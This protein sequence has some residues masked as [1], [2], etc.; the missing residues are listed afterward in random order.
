[1][2]H[3]TLRGRQ[4]RSWLS[5]LCLVAVVSAM[6]L[7]AAHAARPADPAQAEAL[8]RSGQHAEAAQLYEQAA[9]RGFMSWDARLALLAARE[10]AAAGQYGPAERMLA[11][12]E[13]R[14]R[15]D[16][17]VL[18]ARIEAEIA[19]ARNDP[20]RALAALQT[21]PTPLPA[22]VAVD[23]LA[24]RAR[25]EF[26]AGLT[27][28]GVRSLEERGRIVGTAD[29]RAANDRLLAD[30]LAQHPAPVAVPPS[31][32]ESERA[33]L[34]LGQLMAAADGADSAAIARRSADWQA[35]HPGHPGAAFLPRASGESPSTTPPAGPTEGSAVIALLLPLS[36]RQQAAGMAV[37]DGVMA[38]WFAAPAAGRPAIRVYDTA[39]GG[40]VAAY[41]RAVS[42]GGS[43]VIGP[44]TREDIAAV[45]AAQP[46]PV[47]T[48]ALNAYPTDAPPPFLF[49]FSLDPE[50][51]AREVARRIAADG[52]VRGVALFPRS[53]WG[54]RL[55]AAFAAE[56][57]ATGTTLLMSSQYY[58]PGARDFSDALRAALGRFGG[59]GDRSDDRSRPAPHRDPVAEAQAGPQ[60]AFV[61]ATP[62]AARALRP[63]L[64]FQ[65]TY[66]LP[67][68]TTSDAWDPS[69]KSAADMDGLVYPE[70]PW[71]LF[72]G[73]GAPELWETVNSTWSRAS[74]GRLRL[75]AFGFDAYRLAGELR[76][77]VH[78]IGLDGLT[79]PLEIGADGRVQRQLRFARIEDGR[80][81]PL[82]T[83][84]PP[85]PAPDAGDGAP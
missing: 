27:L 22:P 6:P 71:I 12:A 69:V 3:V 40:P 9:R 51:E 60:F 44:L 56:L 21:L 74:R 59:A 73:Q 2:L 53:A 17:A 29:A 68:Y 85:L 55:E 23:L 80:P 75:Y 16:D 81:Q 25:A 77:N 26:A 20:A 45:V 10:Y 34:E 1:M 47:P 18:L 62:Q 30:Q 83:S 84:V 43:L 39:T 72:G 76:G 11:K 38:A 49:Q 63:Q 36:G 4:V 15:G 31:A 67:L 79:G 52:L 82:G 78:A 70:M 54:Q 66:D 42:E 19:L 57:Q 50:Q 61:A 41:Q 48:L 14:A 58:E 33:W 28:A 37:R 13:G 8:A 32:T 64:R 46:L 65:M 5:A 35:R 7:D 24:L